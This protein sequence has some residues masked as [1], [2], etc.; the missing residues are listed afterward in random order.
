MLLLL[1]SISLYNVVSV[2]LFNAFQ[3]DFTSQ[4]PLIKI[5][6]EQKYF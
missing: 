1:V 6:R 2:Y 5:L 4:R 3:F